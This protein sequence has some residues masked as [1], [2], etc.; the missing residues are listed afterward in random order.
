MAPNTRS[1]VPPVNNGASGYANSMQYTA[2]VDDNIRQLMSELVDVRFN[3][4]QESIEAL[5]RVVAAS[6]VMG[7]R[8]VERSAGGGH[9]S[10]YTHMAKLEFP[11]FSG[12]DVN[13]VLARF[14]TVFDDPMYELKNLKYETTTRAYED[15]FDDLLSRVEISKDHAISLFMGGLPVEIAMGVRMF[16]PRKLVDAYCLTNLQE[17]TLNA[18]KKKN[19]VLYSINNSNSTRFNVQNTNNK[20]LLPLPQYTPGHKCSGQMYSLEV[21]AIEDDETQDSDKECLGEENFDEIEEMPQISLN[22]MNGVQNYRAM[23][24]NRTVGKNIIHILVD[25]GSTHNFV[26]IAVAKK[27]GCHIRSTCPLSVTVGDG[28]SIATTSCGDQRYA[29]LKHK[30]EH[31]TK[32]TRIPGMLPNTHIFIN[33]ET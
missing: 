14:G 24:V 18:V 7:E 28:Y 17:A 30:Q 2:V 20:L 22:A 1:L 12:E 21:L 10:S 13:A 26:D 4:M 5:T 3:S 8:N 16:K 25:C 29:I 19:R 32:K 23:R 11:K 31:D 33:E 6:G 9:Q 27:L 15:A